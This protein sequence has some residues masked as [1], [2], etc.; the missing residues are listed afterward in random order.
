MKFD[1]YGKMGGGGVD[2]K[3]FTQ[4]G[5]TKKFRVSFYVVA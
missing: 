5:G 2:G 1:P 3:C 4:A